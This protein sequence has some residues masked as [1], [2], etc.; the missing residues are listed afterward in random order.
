MKLNTMIVSCGY[1]GDAH[2]I[3]NL[4]PYYLH[5]HF[6]VMILSP[7]DSAIHA[8]QVGGAIA[9]IQYKNAGQRAYIGQASLDRQLAHLKLMLEQPYDFFLANDSDSVCLSPKLPEYLYNEDVLWSNEVSDLCHARPDTYTLPRLAFQP[10]YFMSRRVIEKL[11]EAAPTVTTE[12]QTPFIDWCMMAWCMA[13][14]LEHKTFPDGVSCPSWTPDSLAAM[15][16]AVRHQGKIFVHAIKG[17][18]VLIRIAHARIE[19]K[20]AHR[21]S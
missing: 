16:D 6:P 14:G 5:H 9:G 10:P 3:R 17:M 15:D 1:Q 2:Q 12:Q 4:L 11:V 7:S 20:R 21:L 19:Y 13:A 8:H 18:D